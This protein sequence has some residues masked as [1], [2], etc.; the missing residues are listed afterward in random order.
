MGH[1]TAN[2]GGVSAST[3]KKPEVRA[4]GGVIWRETGRVDDPG[5]HEGS[6]IEVV[7]IHRPRHDDWTFPKGKLDKGETYAR[8]AVREVEEE[9]GLQCEL[10]DELP[11]VRYTD[12]KEREKYVR[13]WSMRVVGVG[14]WSPNH[15]VDRRRW[16]SVDEARLLLSYPH[17]RELLTALVSRG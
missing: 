13:Y 14:D 7:V 4:A 17:D 10:G 8:A 1:A 9:T 3:G 15:E 6:G 16:V 12:S 2:H 5:G 11:P